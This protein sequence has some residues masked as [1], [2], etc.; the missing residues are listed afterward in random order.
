M[1]S[2]CT[3]G[4]GAIIQSGGSGTSVARHWYWGDIVNSPYIVFGS[5]CN[6]KDMLKKVNDK[7]VKVRDTYTEISCLEIRGGQVT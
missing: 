5:F 7:Y 4:N 3:L 2:N 1:N 6:S